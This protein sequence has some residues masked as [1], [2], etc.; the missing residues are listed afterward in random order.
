MSELYTAE[1][2]AGASDARG[3]GPARSLRPTEAVEDQSA[4]PL[5]PDDAQGAVLEAGDSGRGRKVISRIRRNPV[6]RMEMRLIDPLGRR[7][8][9]SRMN[10]IRWSPVKSPL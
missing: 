2:G 6:S 1:S 10:R 7:G 5:E 3:G 4:E 8:K 9:A